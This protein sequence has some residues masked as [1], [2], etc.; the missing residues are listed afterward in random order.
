MRFFTVRTC[1]RVSSASSLRPPSPEKPL[2]TSG[3]AKAPE[4]SRA[5]AAAVGRFLSRPVPKTTA[6]HNTQ[7]VRGFRVTYHTFLS[8]MTAKDSSGPA[9]RAGHWRGVLRCRARA[10]R[11]AGAQCD[12][13]PVHQAMK[14]RLPLVVHGTM[15]HYPSGGGRGSIGTACA[16]SGAWFT[17]S[18]TWRTMRCGRTTPSVAP[19]RTA[20]R[21]PWATAAATHEEKELLAIPCDRRDDS[22]VRR[23]NRL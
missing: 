17:T 21:A 23:H 14:T 22:L 12:R 19:S 5:V 2:T 13:G 10:H 15:G 11:S 4:T 18:G 9:G 16:V 1:D 3:G 7:R 8:I 20:A 6:H